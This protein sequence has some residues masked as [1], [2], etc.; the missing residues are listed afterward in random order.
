MKDVNNIHTAD[1][2][3]A[4][5]RIT[6]TTN[7]RLDTDF[8]DCL[9][10]LGAVKLSNPGNTW[11]IPFELEEEKEKIL[12]NLENDFGYPVQI[13]QIVESPD[14]TLDG[15]RYDI[16]AMSLLTSS[17][18]RVKASSLSYT[19]RTANPRLASKLEDISNQARGLQSA[20]LQTLAS[21]LRVSCCFLVVP[22]SDI[23]FGE[24]TYQVKHAEGTRIF[25]CDG[26]I[27]E[28]GMQEGSPYLMDTSTGGEMAQPP[29]EIPVSS[30]D[31][32][33]GDVP[34]ITIQ[35]SPEALPQLMKLLSLPAPYA[36]EAPVPE[37]SPSPYMPQ[38]EGTEEAHMPT[39]E[40]VVTFAPV[41]DGAPDAESPRKLRFF[42]PPGV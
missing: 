33:V 36:E 29:A 25:S 5:M 13:F 30:A 20:R 6:F 18:P 11:D 23:V 7:A 1:S 42:T 14:Q 16:Y 37:V 21:N 9:R 40:S 17:A 4:A 22:S 10:G 38:P 32:M 2:P 19:S 15:R 34:V 3:A 27:G 8:L 39:E 28:I 12:L 35:I 41:E 26:G 24:N 31:D